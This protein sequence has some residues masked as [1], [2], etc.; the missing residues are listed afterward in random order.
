MITLV[1]RR[2]PSRDGMTRRGFLT[3]GSAGVG[4]TLA[5]LFRARARAGAAPAS[6]Q[7]SVIMIQLPGG[8]P[9]LDTYDMKPDAPAEIRG[10]F[11][12]IATSVPGLRICELL[13]LQARTFDRFAVVRSVCDMDVSGHADAMIAT[14]YTVQETEKDQRPSVGAVVS[15]L[16]GNA[17]A[18]PSFAT[19]GCGAYGERAGF[20]GEAHRAF[21]AG[22]NATALANLRL[23]K[24]VDA[25]RLGEHKELLAAFD[26]FRRYLD[27]TDN[28]QRFDPLT[29]RAYDVLTSGA[30]HKALDVSREEPRVRDRYRGMEQLL[31]ARRLVEAGV[32]F[33][34]LE[35]RYRNTGAFGW[36]THYD[37]FKWMREQLPAY[38]RALSV[39]VQ[40]LV[41]RGLYDDVVT[42]AMGEMGRTPRI[43]ANAGRDHWTPV[44]SVLIAGGGLRMGQ[45]I[46]VT[47]SHGAYAKDRPYRV[48]QLLST[49]YRTIGIDPAQTLVSASGRPTHLLDDRNPVVELLS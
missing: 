32:G 34:I 35:L 21:P 6:R 9:H 24:E 40:D 25:R 23:A 30:V 10:E 22:G 39:L 15:K 47:D 19:L 29:R 17:G 7:K 13:P 43:N 5:D 46:G 8:P 28:S 4:L 11:K 33:V 12:P 1:E 18:V 3:I 31:Q 2:A 27:N 16:R 37:N 38:D 41:D 49:L 20:L 48:Q 14:G 42:V 36:D 45:A 44:M 26:G